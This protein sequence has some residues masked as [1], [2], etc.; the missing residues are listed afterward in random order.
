M[1]EGID[2]RFQLH[3][4]TRVLASR[5]GAHLNELCQAQI[6]RVLEGSRLEILIGEIPYKH[7]KLNLML[8]CFSA[9]AGLKY[10]GSDKRG[11]SY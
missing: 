7:T 6:G 3:L 4:H 11:H 10:T 1:F 9:K 5:A 8:C 2:V